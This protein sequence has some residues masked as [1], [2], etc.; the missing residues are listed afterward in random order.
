MNEVNRVLKSLDAGVCP[1]ELCYNA[2]ATEEIDWQKVRYNTFYKSPEFFESKF[3]PE[4]MNLQGF[5]KVIN[6]IVNENKDNSPLKEITQK[7]NIPSER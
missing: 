1:P 7:S 6:L 5:D 4:L 3:P 2:N